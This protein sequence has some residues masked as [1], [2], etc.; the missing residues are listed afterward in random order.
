MAC[1]MIL[2]LAVL[3]DKGDLTQAVKE[4]LTIGIVVSMALYVVVMMVLL[5]IATQLEGTEPP[6]E[7]THG[8]RC[9]MHITPRSSPALGPADEHSLPIK[10]GNVRPSNM[11]QT[12]Q[13]LTH[14]KTQLTHAEIAS[15]DPQ[16]E[17]DM[18]NEDISTDDRASPHVVL[19]TLRV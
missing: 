5:F 14:A 19:G 6:D 1:L 10:V 18:A 13:A 11:G 15:S 8:G 4:G 12:G 2:W 7:H 9:T 16:Q 3:L 17:Q